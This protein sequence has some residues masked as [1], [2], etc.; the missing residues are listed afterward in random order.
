VRWARF[1]TTLLGHPLADEEEEQQ[2]LPKRLALPIFASD[3]L[4]SVAYATEEAMLVLALAGTA[5][6]TR[7]IPVSVAVAALLMVVVVSYT[8]TI[9]AHPDGGGAFIVANENLG[10]IPGAVAAA[11]LLT[12]YV[13][14][15]A[16]SIAAGAAAITSAA[17]GL[18]PWR[19]EITVLLVVLLTV[20][21]LR[22]VKEASTVFAAPTY[23]F[24]AAVVATLVTG[25]IRCADGTCPQA[26]SSAATLEPVTAVG[27]FLVLRAFASGATALTGVEAV[28]NGVPVFRVPKA[29]N[30]SRT[31]LIMGG[32]SITMFIG[33]STLA[34]MF[35]VRITAETV[36]HYGT[37]L[38]QLGRG[39]FG[40]GAAFFGLQVCTAMILVLAAN[41]AY[42]DFPRLSAILATHRLMPR[43]FRNRGDRLVFSNGILALALLASVL[44]VVFHAEVSRL[45]QLYVVGVFT[46]FTLSQAGMVRHWLRSRERGWRLSVVVNGLGAIT[47]GTVLVVVAAVKFS[48]GAW[49]VLA[50]IPLMVVA[51]LRLRRHYRGVG[52]QLRQISWAAEPRPTRVLLFVAHLDAATERAVRYVQM[53]KSQS[54]T[55]VHAVEDDSDD[56]IHTWDLV[57]S[58]MGLELI[59][60]PNESVVGRL[61]DRVRKERRSHPG[62]IITAVVAERYRTRSML[63]VFTHRHC[64]ALR[65]RLLFEPGVVVTDISYRRLRRRPAVALAKTK[66]LR[67]I[68]LVSDFTRPI[69]EAVAYAR[70][71]GA[72]VTCLH[73]DVDDAQRK[74]LLD[75]WGKAGLEIPIE[76]LE[77]HYRGIVGPVVHYVK[78]A[79]RLSLPGTLVNVVIPEF[80]VPGRAAQLL[81]NQTGLVIKGALAPLIGV[82]VTSVPFHLAGRNGAVS[83]GEQPVP[84]QKAE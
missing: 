5:A 3:A 53:I 79:R 44:L 78:E 56:L 77:S 14:T 73:V 18:L 15:V 30:A 60:P 74:R 67:T 43:Q 46:G 2:L 52:V 41:T 33:I 11:A 45:I 47:T 23:L 59:E 31:L 20:I 61:V 26:I 1:K 37:V 55:V 36:D 54:V 42:Q 29:R 65:L 62:T 28:A 34:R 21:N 69:Q 58:G 50:A 51:M 13:L 71:L 72:P 63:S 17:P 7:L 16:V 68:V 12:D 64:L 40:G 76:I 84:A 19:I 80:I 83:A 9:R 70:G 24:V 10:L 39:A 66:H 75:Q 57:Y 48:H 6:F 32:I 8:Q 4:S 35:D 38:S 25:F 27:L 82:A 81:H 22:G 49:I